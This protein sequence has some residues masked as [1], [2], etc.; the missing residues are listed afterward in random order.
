[1]DA[2]DGRFRQ[3]GVEPPR[4]ILLYV[5]QG[6]EIYSRASKEETRRFSEILSGGL[7]NERLI[8]MTSLRSDYYGFLQANEALF[9]LTERIDVPPLATHELEVVLREPAQRLGVGFE[10]EGL[11]EHIVR[12]AQ[13]QPGALPLLADV[14]TE[15][16][17]RM[18][19]R[20]DRTLRITDQKDIVLVGHALASR[21][22]RF[23]DQNVSEQQ[24]VRDLFTLKLVS[25][26]AEGEPVRRRTYRTQCTDQEW[27]LIEMLAEPEWRILVTSQ[28]EGIPS[29]EV[30]HE[31]ILTKWDT[32]RRWLAEER[33]FLIWKGGVER[34]EQEWKKAPFYF[35]RDALLSGNSL[36]QAKG[37]MKT[38]R[39]YLFEDTQ[40]FVKKSLRRKR[41]GFILGI[42]AGITVVL[43]VTMT[44][45]MG[46]FWAE[47]AELMRTDPEAATQLWWQPE[48]FW[49]V[50]IFFATMITIP[51]MILIFFFV[52]LKWLLYAALRF[53]RERRDARAVKTV[54]AVAVQ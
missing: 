32:L 23:L 19:E 17:K 26:P 51:I 15:L 28:S 34:S 20:A 22:D 12:S 21:A 5:D 2:T 41:P 49:R 45:V 35:K 16:W 38:R 33:E 36:F 25:I 7:G 39:K 31:V 42:L 54:G 50:S 27:R 6:E 1:M 52:V 44:I 30:A 43:F 53:R 46:P 9:P 11:V 29:A 37:W 24:A 4:R 14:M 48:N 47:S 3:M 18:Q 13:G 8:V 10:T 40:R